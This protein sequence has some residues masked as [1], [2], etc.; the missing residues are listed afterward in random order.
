MSREKNHTDDIFNTIADH[1]IYCARDE[2]K[3]TRVWADRMVDNLG[4]AE[5]ALLESTKTKPNGVSH[6]KFD[7]W[8]IFVQG[9]ADACT[10]EDTKIEVWKLLC[11]NH[12]MPKTSTEIVVPRKN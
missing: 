8:K 10:D 5:C 3:I 12:G 9:V 4:E 2:K 11:N 7:E 6:K 1:V